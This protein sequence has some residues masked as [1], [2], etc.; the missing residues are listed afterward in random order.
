MSRIVQVFL[1]V[2]LCTFEQKRVA[3]L[4][5][6]RSALSYDQEKSMNSGFLKALCHNPTASDTYNDFCDVDGRITAEKVHHAKVCELRKYG[7]EIRIEFSDEEEI[8][9]QDRMMA[10][11]L[12]WYLAWRF[13]WMDR[14][15]GR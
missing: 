5:V 1:T 3:H 10:L 8:G 15:T 6:T 12:G 4:K 7:F 14:E 9:T 11:F 13:K 2:D